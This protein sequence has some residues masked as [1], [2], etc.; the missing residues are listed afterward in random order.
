MGIYSFYLG[1]GIIVPVARFIRHYLKEILALYPDEDAFDYP[2][3]RTFYDQIVKKY[4]GSKYEAVLLGDDALTS[5]HNNGMGALRDDSLYANSIYTI[6]K[7]QKQ[8]SPDRNDYP[9]NLSFKGALLFIGVCKDLDE[10]GELSYY[11]KGAELLYSLPNFIPQI[12][13]YY[14]VLMQT[15]MTRLEKSRTAGNQ[16]PLIWTFASDCLCCG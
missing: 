2:S 12:I 5:G 10:G 16:R 8:E 7:W 4:I 9:Y 11:V 3:Y 13:A 6:R 15:T 14:P 1:K